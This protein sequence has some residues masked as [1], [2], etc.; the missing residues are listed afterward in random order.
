MPWKKT[1]AQSM[2]THAPG[3]LFNVPW[4]SAKLRMCIARALQ[5]TIEGCSTEPHKLA[6]CRVVS[7]LSHLERKLMH[8]EADACGVFV[9][10]NGTNV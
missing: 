7:S 10:I 9:H 8:D 4:M 1:H 2:G 5:R 6:M 3:I